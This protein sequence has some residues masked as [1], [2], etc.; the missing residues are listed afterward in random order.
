MSDKASS[1]SDTNLDSTENAV[2]DAL[3]IEAESVADTAAPIKVKTVG[4][5]LLNVFNFLLIVGICSAA[6]WTWYQWQQHQ[7]S[8][9]DTG[10]KSEAKLSSINDSLTKIDGAFSKYEA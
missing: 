9:S 6:A 2:E 4:L 1:P 10:P 3:I 7:I 8:D 5:W